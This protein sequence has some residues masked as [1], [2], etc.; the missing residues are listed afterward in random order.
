MRI[1]H[2]TAPATTGTRVTVRPATPADHPRIRAV[3]RAAYGQFAR[4]LPTQVFGPYEAD[5]LDL[6]THARHGILV[7]AEAGGVVLGSGAFYCDTHVQG[8]GWP[9]GWSGGRGLAVHPAARGRGVAQALI[10]ECERLAREVGAPVFAFHTAAFMS[11]AVRLYDHLGYQR[12]PEYDVDLAAH[13]GIHGLAPIPLLA[14]RRDL[15]TALPTQREGTEM[16][17]T[18]EAPTE[19]APYADT[20]SCPECG[21]TAVVEWRTT[22][23]STGL[24]VEHVKIACPSGHRFFMPSEG[25]D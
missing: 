3:L 8:F 16:T 5:L 17:T 19:T 14:Y 13:Y 11:H 6:E 7:V 18:L 23:A 20:V 15:T 9:A 25:L 4:T 1:A 12:A 2:D 10:A 21:Q 24:P 22:I